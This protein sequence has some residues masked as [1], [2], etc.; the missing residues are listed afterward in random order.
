MLGAMAP[1]I[2]RV[3]DMTGKAA[4]AEWDRLA[5]ILNRE[6]DPNWRTRPSVLDQM[7]G[8]RVAASR[9]KRA[10]PIARIAPASAP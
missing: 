9:R 2:A 3:M 5:A 4:A 8:W 6:T 7:R 1:Y 10:R